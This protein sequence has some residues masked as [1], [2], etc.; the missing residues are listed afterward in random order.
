MTQSLRPS[1]T[2]CQTS[3][4]SAGWTEAQPETGFFSDRGPVQILTG[5]L[6][7]VDNF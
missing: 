2:E 3:L 1:H 5:D 6:Y 4:I 7:S